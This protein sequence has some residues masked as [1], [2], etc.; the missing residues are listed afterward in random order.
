MKQL[1]HVVGPCALLVAVMLVI[2]PAGA[3][4][5][6]GNLAAAYPGPRCGARPSAPVRPKAFKDNDQISTY[7][8]EVRRFNSDNEKY[9][10]CVQRYVDAA[11][12]DIRLIRARVK[13]A[14]REASGPAKG[15]EGG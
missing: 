10:T 2:W 9:V 1:R 12:E 5:G 6:Q 11:A 8:A 14:I 3:A 4:F 13:A 7:N 15:A